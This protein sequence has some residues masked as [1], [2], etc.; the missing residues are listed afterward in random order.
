[1]LIN[2]QFLIKIDYKNRNLALMLYRNMLKSWKFWYL[3]F[4]YCWMTL[5]KDKNIFIDILI[6]TINIWDDGHK[7]VLKLQYCL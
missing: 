5:K 6:G 3:V 1:M 7:N 2:V 4:H